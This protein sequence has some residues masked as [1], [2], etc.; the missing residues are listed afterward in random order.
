MT[1]HQVAQQA[2]IPINRL[3]FADTGRIDLEP[4]ELARVKS[5]F[6]QRAKQA[7]AAMA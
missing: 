1:Q 3:A 6:R 2:S 5:V 7:M 4:D